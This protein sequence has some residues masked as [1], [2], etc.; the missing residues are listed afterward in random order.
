[1][2][3]SQ[4]QFEY[5]AGKE[6]SLKG[7]LSPERIGRYLTKAGFDFA[8]AM[9]IYLWNARLAKSLQFPLH[10][11]EVTLRN[12]VNQH[13]ALNRF[14]TDWAFDGPSLNKLAAANSDLISSL[15]KSKSRLLWGKMSRSDYYTNVIAPAH[16]YVPSYNLIS[17][18][19]VIA[20]MSLEFWCSLLDKQFEYEWRP[21]FAKVFPNAATN[22]YRSHLWATLQPIKNLRNRIAHH[23]PLFDMKCMPSLHSEVLSVI[24]KRCAMTMGWTK[25]HSTFTTVWH[26]VPRKERK[27]GRLL[28]DIA[29]PCTE[30][31]SDDCKIADLIARM[32]TGKRRDFLIYRDQGR[33]GLLVA[34]D[35]IRWF[36]SSM[37]HELV[38]MRSTLK[39]VITALSPSA[40][41]AFTTSAATTGDARRLFFDTA[42]RSKDRPTAIVI[43]SD[44]SDI[45]DPIAVVFKPDFQV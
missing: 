34:D 30:V 40:R 39:E 5:D 9:D 26:A 13:L 3:E 21:T 45:G 2:A 1:M 22:E 24:G 37:D 44:G 12:A 32:E 41:L 7:S 10:A 20:A 29:S 6:Q 14:P 28:T 16:T 11:L 35:L 25:H 38:D 15:N 23:E 17:T 42:L 4:Y 43:T 18:N 31:T 19:D 8:Y 33:L 27:T 36:R